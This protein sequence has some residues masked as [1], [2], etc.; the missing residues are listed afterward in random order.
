MLCL[1]FSRVSL[2]IG[3]WVRS[4]LVTAILS[5]PLNLFPK[6]FAI[7]SLGSNKPTV[8]T[9]IFLGDWSFQSH[10]FWKLDACSYIVYFLQKKIKCPLKFPHV[11]QKHMH[12]ATLWDKN[13]NGISYAIRTCS[14]QDDFLGSLRQKKRERVRNNSRANSLWSSQIF[15]IL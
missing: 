5:S 7:S 13:S 9:D 11:S 8:S 1:T 3:T 15:Q 10:G 2:N 14:I 12:C 6:P 4:C